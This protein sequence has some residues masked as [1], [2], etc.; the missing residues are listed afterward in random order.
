M[1]GAFA[2]VLGCIGDDDCLQRF[3]EAT[4]TAL[5]GWACIE[6]A[7]FYRACVQL[8]HGEPGG[9]HLLRNGALLCG[10][11]YR[12]GDS[13]NLP[14]TDDA[15]Q[16]LSSQPTQFAKWQ[17]DKYWGRYFAAVVSLDS[18]SVYLIRDP[19]GLQTAYYV[20]VKGGYLFSNCLKCL[21]VTRQVEP[22]LNERFL[23]GYVRYGNRPFRETPI[24]G[25]QEL[26]A[27]ECLI[28]N[29]F[30]AS[31]S[32]SVF[33]DLADESLQD[34]WVQAKEVWNQ[35]L[36]VTTKLVS[37]HQTIGVDLSGGLDSSIVLA[38]AAESLGDRKSILRP[39]NF[40]HPMVAS[41][42]ER[43]LAREAA[44]RWGLTVAEVDVSQC[45]PFS[46][47]DRV[48]SSRFDR[49]SPHLVITALHRMLFEAT[50]RPSFFLNGFGGDHVFHAKSGMPI[51]VA[52]RFFHWQCVSGFNEMLN[53]SYTTNTP[54]WSVLR[55]CWR[56]LS[57]ADDFAV[58]LT[59][60][61]DPS[62]YAPQLAESS[63]DLSFK[64]SWWRDTKAMS[65]MK[66]A[67]IIELFDCSSQTDRYYRSPYSQSASPLI[68]WPIIKL[69]TKLRS[70]QLVTRTRDRVVL[71]SAATSK[72]PI[73]IVDRM[74][75]GE[76]SG[77]FHHGFAANSDAILGLVED[78]W[79]ARNGYI[80]RE[81]LIE[82]LKQASHG[83]TNDLWPVV[84]LVS[85]EVWLRG[86]KSVAPHAA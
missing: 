85:I 4:M 46:E 64:P 38:S 40:F 60:Q 20:R 66:R 22:K 78:G 65:P 44:H 56:L 76:H 14:S 82:A 7:P 61:P 13:S 74:D 28:I 25:V 6:V 19:S 2:D 86:W 54:L 68:Q 49:P 79:A 59:D 1:S 39:V 53:Y 70:S 42:D 48:P 8:V 81:G 52:D 10:E 67:Q 45:L 50:G 71:R 57:E 21:L 58:W 27:G 9:T 11:V 33:S 23:C 77:F 15:L 41:G 24:T 34:E 80:C 75:K 30:G 69:A 5:N 16:E 73:Q 83:F 62:W 35:I 32:A 29:K 26:E 12:S 31:R 36:D 63:K 3:R 18:A 84:N 17:M 37:R 55:H 43:S 51:Q 47:L 72:V